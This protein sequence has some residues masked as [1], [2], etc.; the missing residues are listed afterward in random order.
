MLHMHIKWCSLALLMC[1]GS[2]AFAF[3]APLP[4]TEDIP[5]MMAAST[6]VCKGAVVEAPNPMFVPS[7]V[8]ITQL[9]ATA[10]LRPDRCFKGTANGSSIPVLFDGF[11]SGT[12]PSFVLRKG[13]YRLFF[14]KLQNGKYT[15]VDVWFGALSISRNV[16]S[17]PENSDGIYLLELD[18]KAGLQ[19]STPERVLDSIRMLGNMRHL[20]STSELTL[21]LGRPVLL[22]KDYV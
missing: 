7:P 15:V 4:G 5:K 20:H 16:G 19:D 11:V 10:S 13:D 17:V 9:T 8:G 12:G 6:L 1:L 21:L 22:L 3:P 2:D 18:L 14:L